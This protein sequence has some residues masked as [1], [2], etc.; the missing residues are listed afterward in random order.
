VG[1]SKN[2]SG[3]ASEI[4]FRKKHKIKTQKWRNE[5]EQIITQPYLSSNLHGTSSH[6]LQ[7]SPPSR[8]AVVHDT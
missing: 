1:K 8:V 2:E 6:L 3:K 7:S 5:I 4:G